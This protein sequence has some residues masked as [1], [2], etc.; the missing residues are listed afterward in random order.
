[1]V[2]REER[3]AHLALCLGA[4]SMQRGSLEAG[5]RNGGVKEAHCLDAIGKY[6]NPGRVADALAGL[7]HPRGS[8]GFTLCCNANRQVHAPSKG[9]NC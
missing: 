7:L 1:M 8:E 6:Q 5:S 4:V 3:S 2:S 9:V